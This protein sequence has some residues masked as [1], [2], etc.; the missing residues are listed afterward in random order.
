MTHYKKPYK[1]DFSM[2]IPANRFNF[3]LFLGVTPPLTR[4]A[5]LT[6]DNP[7]DFKDI[8]EKTGGAN[9]GGANAQTNASNTGKS[10]KQRLLSILQLPRQ[11]K[12]APPTTSPFSLLI[13]REQK[14]F[15]P[16]KRVRELPW[17]ANTSQ[18]ADGNVKAE[19]S[20]RVKVAMLA[21]LA[22][23]NLSAKLDMI[24]ELLVII[25]SVR[26]N[27]GFLVFATTHLPYK[28]DPALRRPGRLDETLNLALQPSLKDR[29]EMIKLNFSDHSFVNV[30][31]FDQFRG[32]QQFETNLLFQTSLLNGIFK[33]SLTRTFNTLD[34]AVLFE[35]RSELEIQ[36]LFLTA[37][38]EN[39][40]R[41]ILNKQ[42]PAS[43]VH[44]KTAGL[45][46]EIENLIR[47]D[48]NQL[49]GLT[50]RNKLKISE[51]FEKVGQN[52]LSST[53]QAQAET[54]EKAYSYLR[55]GA[56][57][58]QA[59]IYS[60]TAELIIGLDLQRNMK[61][62]T[63]QMVGLSNAS[64]NFNNSYTTLYAPTKIVNEEIS[65]RFANNIGQFLIFSSFKPTA[66]EQG[67]KAK[68]K[69]SFNGKGKV[70]F[71][72]LLIS[73]HLP[74]FHLIGQFAFNN[75]EKVTMNTSAQGFL[76]TVNEKRRIHNQYSL[77]FDFLSFTESATLKEPPGP[78]VTS[79]LKPLKKYENLQRTHEDYEL[80]PQMTIQEKIQLHQQQRFLKA[81]YQ[82]PIQQLFKNLSSSNSGS[83]SA[84]GSS[85]NNSLR[86]LGYYDNLLFKPS[87]INV[88]YRNRIL[89]RHRYYYTNQW[90]TGQLPEHT[91]EVTFASDVDWRSRFIESKVEKPSQH[92]GG[93]KI[94][95]IIIDFPDPDQYYNPRLR[96]WILTNGVWANWNTI[97][98]WKTGKSSQFASNLLMQY[99]QKT[100]TSL[101]FYREKLDYLSYLFLRYGKI[102]ELDFLA[103]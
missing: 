83:T 5:N 46:N 89:N 97:A 69:L 20:V 64:N 78:S 73:N 14:K 58:L 33:N 49:F 56:L 25:D 50:K 103:L 34:Y 12:F 35:S 3:Q 98:N 76:L 45:E 13:L 16:K 30:T 32:Q 21:D 68:P 87:S 90:W 42:L 48:L 59:L 17:F 93:S 38:T 60:R 22:I 10:T 26:S 86:D 8:Q 28:L 96:R 29:L 44:L 102:H 4:R 40:R 31:N 18:T 67:E 71:T 81:L 55:S 54:L 7:L 47:F 94:E 43:H 23:S 92:N 39:A 57:N 70:E 27:H 15:K 6:I 74:P 9:A 66:I 85:F 63:L 36:Q 1:G 101:S 11:E 79:I 75:G 41:I 2:S 82:K 24:T 91:I 100:Y 37:K 72:N 77:I 88:Y 61:T 51:T 53:F 62:Y 99:F 19:Y 84:T 80:K 52:H 65:R 95:D